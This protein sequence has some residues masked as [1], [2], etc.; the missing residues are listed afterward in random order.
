MGKLHP[1]VG[2]SKAK[3]HLCVR[4]ADSECLDHLTLLQ[5]SWK[6]PFQMKRF[7]ARKRKN[8]WQTTRENHTSTERGE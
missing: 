6:W 8:A 5:H 1:G 7:V 2:G 4:S 3:S